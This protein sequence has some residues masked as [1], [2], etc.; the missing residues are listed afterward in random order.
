DVFGRMIQP[1]GEQ[2]KNGKHGDSLVRLKADTTGERWRTLPESAGGHYRRALVMKRTAT[3]APAACHQSSA[4]SFNTKVPRQ[5][6]TP[7]KN[8]N[9]QYSSSRL[10]SDWAS[11]LATALRRTLS[12]I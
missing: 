11:M 12:M 2:Q 1:L 10:S 6:I 3:M 5:R 7:A 4:R 8:R 9:C